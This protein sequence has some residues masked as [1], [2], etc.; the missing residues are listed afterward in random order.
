MEEID[1]LFEGQTNQIVMRDGSTYACG[2]LADLLHAETADVLATY[3]SDFYAGMPVVTRNKFGEGS[4]FYIASDPEAAFLDRFYAG[5]LTHYGI[6]PLF[7][8]PPN[9][10]IAIR[11]KGDQAILFILNH[12]PQP[13]TVE[14]NAPSYRDLLSGQ[15]S[16]QRLTLAGYDVRILMVDG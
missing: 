10:E 8:T 9:V 11:K 7:A 14:L 13:V 2:H 4:A 15:M 12:N 16:S 1:A 3:G 6:A 5:L